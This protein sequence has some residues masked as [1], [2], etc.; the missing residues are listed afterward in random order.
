MNKLNTLKKQKVKNIF[1]FAHPDDEFTVFE[2]IRIMKIKKQKCLFVFCTHTYR[3]SAR[4]RQES[5]GVLKKLGVQS[6]ECVFVEDIE[7]IEDGFAHAN[8]EILYECI[9]S[10]LMQHTCVENLF[11]PAFEG[12]H[13]DHDVVHGVVKIAAKKI[14]C[15]ARI[16]ESYI[17]NSYNSGFTY[18]KILNVI[19]ENQKQ[20]TTKNISIINRVKFAS[21]CFLY[22]SQWKTWIFLMP[23][24]IW[25]L[26][27]RGTEKYVLTSDDL[28]YLYCR[29]HK[30]KILYEKRGICLFQD[31]CDG[32][33]K[34]E[35]K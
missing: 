35:L 1:F 15:K 7:I 14:G 5:I 27:F 4:R 31:I 8:I 3:I 24:F 28:K 19:C 6:E 12:G 26:I 9:L 21:L 11:I 23:H 33:K 34:I 10:L 22:F 32:L 18:F 30:G 20:V 29:P 17:Y 13:Q 25:H 16:F 2:C